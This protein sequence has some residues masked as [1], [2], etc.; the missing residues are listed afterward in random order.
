M[1]S[2]RQTKPKVLYL[3]YWGAAEPLGQSLVLPAVTKLADLGVDLTLVTFEKPDDLN[4]PEAMASVREALGSSGI[5]WVPLRY[6]KRPKVPATVFDFVQG[7]ARSVASRLRTRPDIIHARTF[8]GGLIGMALAPV[9]RARLVYHNEGFYPDEQVDAGVWAMNSLPHR[10]AKWLETKMYSRADAVISLSDAGK[11]VIAGLPSLKNKR[12]PVVVVPSCVD[13]DHFRLNKRTRTE[14]EALRFVYSGS[15][16]GRYDLQKLAHFVAV[17][18]EVVGPVKLRVLTRSDRA[19]VESMLRAGGLDDAL[20]SI[21]SVAYSAMPDA[22]CE[23]DVGLHF[24]PMGISD[25]GGSPTKI[26]EYWA[27]GLP[28][29]VTPNAGDVDKIAHREQVGVI[30]EGHNDDAY[31][32]AA[33]ELRS[34]LQESDLAERCRRAAQ[35]HYGL[36]AACIRQRDLYRALSSD[37]SRRAAATAVS[38][39]RNGS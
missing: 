16:G 1:T 18:A 32:R 10:V 2:G 34:L 30:V 22:L 35:S 31:R 38:E 13:L 20:W 27:A 8:I 3:V 17:A 5:T 9:L 28:I 36:E 7:C 24:L 12:T 6:H 25:H 14:G 15:A 37:V 33:T 26:G 39:V 29:V 19:L 23:E 11:S 21:E 4:R